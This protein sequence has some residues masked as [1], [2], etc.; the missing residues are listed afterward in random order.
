M[1]S[2]GSALIPGECE[3][4]PIFITMEKKMEVIRRI[5]DGQTSPYVCRSMKLP[6]S[7]V[8]S[9]RKNACDIKQAVQHVGTVLVE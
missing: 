4:S 2:V 6:P 9:I 5:E 3:K 1:S 7:T 8:S